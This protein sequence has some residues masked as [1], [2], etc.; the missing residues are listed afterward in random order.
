M[1]RCYTSL[2]SQKVENQELEH[3]TKIRGNSTYQ[4]LAAKSSVIE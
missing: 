1:S 4:H 2:H 3:K